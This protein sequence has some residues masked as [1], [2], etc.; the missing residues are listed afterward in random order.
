MHSVPGRLSVFIL[1]FLIGVVSYG[2]KIDVSGGFV[3]DS[4]KIGQDIHYW[5]KAKYPSNLELILPDTT[6]D[7]SPFE[8]SAKTYFP[9]SIQGDII[10]DSAVYTLQSY[11]IDPVQ[12]LSLPA[13]V[14]SNGDSTKLDAAPDSIYFFELAPVVTDTTK[15]KTNLA[16]QDVNTEF[17]YPVLW[18]VI[19]VLA[20]LALIVFLVFG[21]KIKKY[22]QLKR[23]KKEYI[24]FSEDLTFSIRSLKKEPTQKQAE[25][26]LSIWKNFLEKLESRPFSKLTTKEIMALDYT[27]ELNGT[28]KNIDRCVFGGKVTDTLYKDFQAIEDFTQYR[29]S[30]II[31]QIKN[32]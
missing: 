29:Y 11:E 25:H 21:K 12:Y 13:F 18:I 28:L 24:Q 19:A 17:N 30:V 8:F 7:F 9:S 20:V 1:G 32:G 14:I 27:N 22:F 4:L 10:A 16:Y 26:A 5:L 3:E 2:Q 6:F 15:L 31:D 23:L